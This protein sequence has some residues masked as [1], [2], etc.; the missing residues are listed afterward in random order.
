M[1]PSELDDGQIPRHLSPRFSRLI[2]ETGRDIRYGLRA[3]AGLAAALALSRTIEGLLF[4]VKSTDVFTFAA[5]SVLL[6]GVA[7]AASYLPARRAARVDAA[8]ALRS[9]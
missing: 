6:A 2:E 3:L 8:A 5:V 7:L 1:N 9:E 4:G